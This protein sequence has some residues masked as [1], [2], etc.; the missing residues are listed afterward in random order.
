MDINYKH[1]MKKGF[2]LLELMIV[3][4]I[5]GI[6]ATIGVQQY[7]PAKERAMGKEAQLNLRLIAAAERVYRMENDVYYPANGVTVS[8]INSINSNLKLN[9]PTTN[10]IYQIAGTATGYTATASRRGTGGYLDCQW[11]VRDSA[12]NPVP[13]VASACAR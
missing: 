2:T 5:V 7:M 13:V 9:I 10:W 4:I 1:C 6:L 12:V 3:V 11:E 8:A